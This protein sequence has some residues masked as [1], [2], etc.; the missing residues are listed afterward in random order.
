MGG[1]LRTVTREV[2][3]L[4]LLL[5]GSKG[6]G[7]CAEEASKMPVE[8]RLITKTARRGDLGQTQGLVAL[9]NEFACVI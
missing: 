9:R 4:N 8:V 6:R 2:E 7:R 3:S 5:Q 1:P